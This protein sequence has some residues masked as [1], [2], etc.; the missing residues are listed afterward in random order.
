MRSED[1]IAMMEEE[2]RRLKQDNET[3]MKTIVQMKTTINRLL[4]RYISG[5]ENG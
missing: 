1:R 3:L 5:K 2:I 4:I